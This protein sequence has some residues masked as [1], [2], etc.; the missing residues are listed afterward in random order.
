[1]KI[2]KIIFIL[3]LFFSIACKKPVNFQ[4]T[5][6]SKHNIPVPNETVNV[7]WDIGNGHSIGSVKTDKQGHYLYS[8]NV[9]K[10]AYNFGVHVYSDSG[11]YNKLLD[12]DH[13]PS[14]V[15]IHL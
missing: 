3:C 9:D 10:D 12:K 15:D 6:Y 7:S 13:L 8:G 14:I 11:A 4:G 2:L 1:M 5:M